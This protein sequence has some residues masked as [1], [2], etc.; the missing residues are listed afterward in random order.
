[1]SKTRR[2]RDFSR[3]PLTSTGLLRY[4]A[5][6]K[7]ESETILPDSFPPRK[8]LSPLAGASERGS[9]AVSTTKSE[10]AKHHNSPF[11]GGAPEYRESRGCGALFSGLA[12]TTTAEP[13]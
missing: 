4:S 3:A 11:R 12:L 6:A 8:T 5:L 2:A 10:Q 7:V 1:M 13:Q 9:S